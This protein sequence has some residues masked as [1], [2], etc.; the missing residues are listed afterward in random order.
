MTFTYFIWYLKQPKV[1]V[2]ILTGDMLTQGVVSDKTLDHD[3]SLSQMASF[4]EIYLFFLRFWQNQNSC[5]GHEMYWLSEW[6]SQAPCHLTAS[7]VRSLSPSPHLRP[8]FDVTI[9]SHTYSF[10][11]VSYDTWQ[12]LVMKEK[13]IASGVYKSKIHAGTWFSNSA[14]VL[15]I[16]CKVDGPCKGKNVV[17]KMNERVMRGLP[18][19][20]MQYAFHRRLPIHLKPPSLFFWQVPGQISQIAP[21]LLICEFGSLLAFLYMV[22]LAKGRE[23]VKKNVWWDTLP[24]GVWKKR[25]DPVTGF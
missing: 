9:K 21:T 2:A 16:F 25:E 13:P 15:Q 11:F 1:C 6:K 10:I 7:Q 5:W 17:W 19:P 14:N 3:I 20:A 22:G 4:R 12:H 23:R 24:A 18:N 8:S